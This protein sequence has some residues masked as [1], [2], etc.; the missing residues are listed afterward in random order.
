MMTGC[1]HN[2][3]EI[4]EVFGKVTLDGTPVKGATVYFYPDGGG[5]S[6]ISKTNDD[7]FYELYYKG[8]EKG[9]KVGT[10]AVTLTTATE[11]TRDEKGKVIKGLPEKFPK[12]YSSEG[13]VKREVKPGRNEINFEITTM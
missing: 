11:D 12:E 2:G 7:G 8:N 13:S 3:P 9:A 6:S 4:G 1:G 10:H 5:R